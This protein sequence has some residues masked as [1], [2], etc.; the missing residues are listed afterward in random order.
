VI[1]LS[2][3]YLVRNPP[4]HIA[5]VTDGHIG[6]IFHN[7]EAGDRAIAFCNQLGPH[8]EIY[9]GDMVR[10][11]S[12][13]E[14][15]M[16]FDEIIGSEFPTPADQL[17]ELE[18]RLVSSRNVRENTYLMIGNHDLKL[19]KRTGNYFQD[20]RGL[21]E[22][23]CERLGVH[24]GGFEMRLHLVWDDGS[25]CRVLC[26]HGRTVNPHTRKVEPGLGHRKNANAAQW[27][28]NDLASI[29]RGA[30]DLYLKG[31]E[32]RVT[33]YEPW[34]YKQMVPEGDTWVTKTV[35]ESFIDHPVWVACGGA[36]GH[37]R[38]K[39]YT[40]YQEEG[41]MNGADIAMIHVDLTQKEGNKRI[42]KINVIGLG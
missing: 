26:T 25:D 27:L 2:Q 35:R 31:H 3:E 29:D 23:M 41:Q 15:Y 33:V 1:Y 13:N 37:T 16:N 8:L 28:R 38:V 11:F 36:W 5:W 22:G 24:Y 40:T 10:A 14:K 20:P 32:H 18:R 4:P 12:F 19:F 34:E 7:I 30:S 42:P 39:G 6:D 9:G 17:A 21:R